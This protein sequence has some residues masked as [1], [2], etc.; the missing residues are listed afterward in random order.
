MKQPSEENKN[1]L[2]NNEDNPVVFLDVA[3]GSE[4]GMNSKVMYV[5]NTNSR[6]YCFSVGRVVIELFKDVVP[7]TAENF[8]VLCTGEKGAGL[9]AP[10]LH[11]KGT[12]FHKGAHYRD[13]ECSIPYNFIPCHNSKAYKN[14]SKPCDLKYL[15]VPYLSF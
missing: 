12:I 14:I 15:Y 3:I 13:H 6:S 4:K 8:R 10:K 1:S 2:L 9:K 7:R 5:A 11:Y